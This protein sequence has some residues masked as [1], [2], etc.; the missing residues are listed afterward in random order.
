M[1]KIDKEKTSVVL[2]AFLF[3]IIILFFHMSLVKA[4]AEDKGE[5]IKVGVYELKNF[6]A[7]DDEGNVTGYDVDY[8][9]RISE[10]TG[11]KYKY[12]KADSWAQGMEMLRNGQI[13]LLSPAQI[14]TE[15]INEFSFST[16]PEGKVYGAVLTLDDR[17]DIVYED[18]DKFSE[19]TFGVEENVTYGD[20]FR[21]YAENRGF[22]CNLKQYENSESLIAGL[23]EGEVDAIIINIMRAE[24]DMKLVGKAGTALYYYMYR[25]E[26]IKLGEQLNQAMDKI[27]IDNSDFQDELVQK[28]F[29]IYNEDSFTKA[30]LDYIDNLGTLNVSVLE[31]L[32][33]LSYKDEQTGKITGI[34][35]EFLNKISELTGIK[36]QY[37][38]YQGEDMEQYIKG[39][40]IDIISG[41]KNIEYGRENFG[42]YY[43]NSYFNTQDVMVCRSEYDFFAQTSGTL[44]L[45]K[46]ASELIDIIKEM[47]PGYEIIMYDTVKETFDAVK[48]SEADCTLLSSYIVNYYLN[49]PKYENLVMVPD[50]GIYE[51]N[52][53]AIT[54]EM[55]DE[56]KEILVSILN[57]GIKKISQEDQQKIVIKYTTAMPYH[58]DL[59]EVC[60]KYRTPLIVIGILI[61]SL[62]GLFLFY[63]RNRNQHYKHTEIIN[64]E[65]ATKNQQLALAI[66]EANKAN[67][68]KS[69]FLAQMSH[70]IRTPM[71]AII[72]LSSIARADIRNPEKMTD[73]LMKIDSS[74]RLL[75][76]IIN[77]VLDMSAIES[78]KMKLADAEFDFKQLLSSV[79]T[80]FYHQC[81]Q[82]GIN[83]EMKVNG[84]TEEVIRGDSLRVNQILMNILS[85]AAKFT[86]AGGEITVL[87]IQASTSKDMV[88]MRFV[89]SDTGC[90]MTEELQNRLFKPF[91]QE[92]ATTARK[93]GG[94]GLGLSITKNL[95]ELMNGYI[96]VESEKDVGSTFTVDIPFGKVEHDIKEETI[97]HF[98]NV[99]ALIV[100]DD[101]DAGEYTG[102]ILERLG[103][104]YK[105]VSSGEAALE[106]LGEAE[107]EGEIYNMCFVDWKMPDMDGVEVTEQI[108]EIFGNDTMVIIVSA[109]DLNEIEADGKRAG[110]DYFIPKPLFQST[111]FNILMKITDGEYVKAN[112]L[113]DNHKQ[114]DFSGKK[115]LVAEDVT[116]NMEVAVRLLAMVGVEAVCAEDGIQAVDLFEKSKEGEYDAILLDINMPNKDG[117]EAAMDIRSGSHPD[118]KQIPIYAM[119]ANAFTEDVAA[120]LN[121]GMN[122]HIAKPIETEV[123]YKTLETS[124]KERESKK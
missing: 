2:I 31:D 66:E 7:F 102:S 17:D 103:I 37:N 99:R 51:A 12:I 117:Y 36:F 52:S 61:I 35:I 38:I 116:L 104:D 16:Y 93:H 13:D 53:M 24:D 9:N 119:T 49:K 105:Y 78:K 92:S 25:K 68:A 74:S 65:L 55:A 5:T 22:D 90:G 94:S 64:E 45:C 76:G 98:K 88:H 87:V 69:Q 3:V 123:L 42:S 46:N 79:T 33:P 48:K 60:Y 28:Y 95:V 56:D 114:Y 63:I 84:V 1:R 39:E 106:E 121:A 97:R 34:N 115:V 44:A 20:I 57:K 89:I 124:F 91:E 54:G 11:W 21:N 86:S 82:K 112:S 113:E 26:D 75:L 67:N 107:D 81:K 30:E 85:N 77:D 96:K 59:W 50:I 80:V 111:I 70:E 4:Y 47:Y 27:E 32:R 72:G 122:G 109:Y 18:Y 23:R 15:R 62:A 29:P 58:M 100:D 6:H 43:T 40:N 108:R 71:N 73:Y 120:A 8:L 110:A 118:G 10:I 14:T 83:F 19:L 41:I 101:A